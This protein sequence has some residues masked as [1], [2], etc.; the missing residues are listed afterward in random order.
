MSQLIFPEL[1]GKESVSQLIEVVARMQKMLN[2]VVN[3]NISSQNVREI[4]GWKVDPDRFSSPDGDVG[5]STADDGPDPVRLWAGA[6]EPTEGP[7]RVTQSGKMHATG[8]VI[9][10]AAGYPKI[11]LDPDG[12]L[13]GAYLNETTYLSIVPDFSGVP[14]VLWYKDGFLQT[15][16]GPISTGGFIFQV[17]GANG[18][19]INATQGNLDLTASSKVR[20]D[21]WAKLY[22]ID[23]GVTLQDE[24]NF[25]QPAFTG[26]TGTVY[27]SATPGGPA[28]IPI[29]FQGG[30][31]TV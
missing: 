11:E 4:S 3:G 26:A 24:L 15:S 18:L 28:N 31:R 19:T 14:A 21:N 30:I 25:K 1:T 17:K 5:L 20:V 9:E 2:F 8:A 6:A 27:V 7:W 23:S 16:F 22:S 10:S 29:T 12:N 13:V